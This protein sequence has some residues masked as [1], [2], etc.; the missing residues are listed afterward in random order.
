MI[1]GKRVIGYMAW[2][3]SRLPN[4]WVKCINSTV[5]EVWCPSTYN[6]EVFKNSGVKIPIKVFPHIF[7]P[8]ELPNRKLVSLN[9]SKYYTF[10]NISELNFRKGVEDL[11]KVFCDTFTSKDK[12]RLI[13][14]IHYRNYDEQSKKHCVDKLNTITSKHKH[15]P[16]IRYILNNLSE[17]EMLGLHSIGDCYVSL[18]KSEGFGLTIFEAFKYGK[19]V[20]TTGYG[21]QIDFLGKDYEGLVKYKLDSITGMEEFSKNYTKDQLW[22]YPDLKHAGELMKDLYVKHKLR[23]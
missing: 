16:R 4:Y 11:V 10:Y 18:C 19:K 20:I 22:A 8:K 12:V 2:E 9:D 6:K 14:K 3:S 17:K 13:L 23:I 15:P 1:E 7:L 5:E 21:G